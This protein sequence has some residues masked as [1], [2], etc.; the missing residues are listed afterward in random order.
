MQTRILFFGR[1]RCFRGTYDVCLIVAIDM[2]N[3][4]LRFFMR[5]LILKTAFV[6][7]IC[8]GTFV[9][10]KPWSIFNF[11]I[12]ITRPMPLSMLT[13]IISTGMDGFHLVPCHEDLFICLS[14]KE[15]GSILFLTLSDNNWFK[16]LIYQWPAK[17]C[18][19]KFRDGHGQWE[20]NC[21]TGKWHWQLASEPEVGTQNQ[22][23]SKLF[24]KWRK[25][26]S[27]K[28]NVFP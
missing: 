14:R 24:Y 2:C 25:W 18:D 4:P 19:R 26:W 8:G 13:K 20:P 22:M 11:S 7:F 3:S 12:F 10:R 16:L 5:N 17:V 23:T 6:F 9:L 21:V 28:L 15:E 27:I 1:A